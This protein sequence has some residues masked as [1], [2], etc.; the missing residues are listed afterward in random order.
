MIDAHK[1]ASPATTDPFEQSVEQQVDWPSRYTLT[2]LDKIAE[3]LKRL[4]DFGERSRE[5]QAETIVVLDDFVTGGGGVRTVANT[6]L[7]ITKIVLTASGAGNIA[8]GIGTRTFNW[9]VPNNA[10]V[11]F[12]F[13]MDISVGSNITLGGAATNAIVYI[14]AYTV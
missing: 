7:K 9:W 3:S 2:Q 11:C 4:E 10:C 6:S 14:L 12:D 1:I 13:P 8:L 5:R